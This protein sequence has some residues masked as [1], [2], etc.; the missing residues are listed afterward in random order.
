MLHRGRLRMCAC[1]CASYVF[2]C[3]AK[4]CLRPQSFL[5]L[6]L[7]LSQDMCGKS[8]GA[9]LPFLL[10]D[11]LSRF[12]QGGGH[13]SAAGERKF[14]NTYFVE[15]LREASVFSTS[16]LSNPL[17]RQSRRQQEQTKFYDLRRGITEDFQRLA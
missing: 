16:R 5:F 7:S 6:R 3:L 2:P 8:V 12:L 9:C 13:S 14:T 17:H 15:T 11:R 1:A 4:T 10:P